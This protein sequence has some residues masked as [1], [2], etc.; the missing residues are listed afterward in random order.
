MTPRNLSPQE[1]R[2]ESLIILIR[3]QRV[4]MDADLA[5]LYR[6]KTK[7][8]LQ[9]VK[10]NID[11]FPPDFM[12]RLKQ[13]EFDNLRSQPVTSRWGGRRYCPYVFTEQGVAM[14]SSVLKSKRAVQTNI[15]I[16]RAFVRL[17]SILF[18]HKELA[19]KQV[20][21]E[22]KY[23]AQFKVVFDAIRQ[24]MKEEKKPKRSIGFR[25]E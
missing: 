1:N 14:L 20:D 4:I 21:L 8:L 6:V 12:F 3:G 13:N 22:R 24:L 11:R 17:R 2:A 19:V 25:Q 5:S 7:V 16:M 18:A 15:E 23:D 9:S 10:R